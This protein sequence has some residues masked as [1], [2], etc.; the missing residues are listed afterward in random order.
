VDGHVVSKLPWWPVTKL[1]FFDNVLPGRFA[2]YLSLLLAVIVA[3]WMAAQRAGLLRWLLPLL[4]I[5]A[6]APS[7]HGFV[8]RYGT[9]AFFA[10][11]SYRHC[12]GPR[13]TLLLLPQ[14]EQILDQA[15]TN[16]RFDLAGGY[17]GPGAI[18]DSYLT[19]PSWY[20]IAIGSPI[21]PDQLLDLRTFIAAKH[22]TAIVVAYYDYKQFAPAFNRLAKPVHVGGETLYRLSGVQA[23]CPSS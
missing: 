13:E 7:P 18:P 9:S 5:V 21:P 19:P 23:P 17:V 14:P 12:L 20:S 8:T 4:A 3:L 1:P 6:I 15:V 2:A 16:F 10:D 11:S 22:V